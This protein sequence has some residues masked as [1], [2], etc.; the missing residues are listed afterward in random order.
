MKEKFFF[1]LF[2]L[3]SLSKA[4]KNYTAEIIFSNSEIL[5][6][7]EGV[8]ISGT[9]ATIKISGS[10]Y[11]TGS[12]SEGNILINADLVDLNLKD[13]DLSSRTNSP[14]IVKSN[15]QKVTITS[16][17]NVILQDLEDQ[18]TTIGECAVIKI[19]KMS[20]VTF[21]NEKELKLIGK[22]KNVIKGGFKSNI[23][24]NVSDGEYIINAYNNGISSDNLIQFNGGK[25]IINTENGDA[26]KSSPDVGDSESLGKIEVNSGEFNI[27]SHSDAFQAANK[28]II[29]GGN[30]NIKTEDGYDSKSFNKTTMSAKGFKV[31]NNVTG[32][33]IRVYDGEF[34][35]NTADDAFHSNGNLTLI[36]GNYKIYSGDDALHAKFHLI[37]GTKD[38]Y[39]S[40][41]IN[42]LNSYEAIEGMSIRIYSGNINA[43]ARDD[44]LNAAG[45]D[46]EGGPG[47]G[48]R[49]PG[50]R[51]PRPNS[52]DIIDPDDPNPQPGPGPRPPGPRPPRPNSTDI[53]DPDDPNPQPGPGP[54]PPGPWPPGPMPGGRGNAN[55]FISIYGGQLN[56]YCSADGFDSNGNIFIH[57]GDIN[58]FS[59]A[60]GEGRNNE[61]ID[62]DGNFTLFDG[63]LF[64]AGNKG[65]LDVHSGILKGN[66]MYAYYNQSIAANNTLKIKDGNNE[67]IK[68]VT[69]P[70]TVTYTFF[71]CKGFNENYQFY[72]YDTNGNESKLAFNFG[73][74]KSGSDDQDIKADD[75]G[76]YDGKEDLIDSGDTDSPNKNEEPNNFIAILTISLCSGIIVIVAISILLIYK[77]KIC[78]QNK[79]DLLAEQG[80][81]IE[82]NINDDESLIN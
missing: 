82:Y 53:I 80:E 34:D 33:I 38:N 15:L 51:P 12:S 65:M 2:L 62:H 29:R 59:Q 11:I 41:K 21:H 81:I 47:P 56:I 78:K 43:T 48:P 55:Y 25:F 40:P 18:N 6:S 27:Q 23:I 63:T 7:G 73:T 49:P 45:G 26:I 74:P 10:F 19:K 9:K 72:L 57:G 75:G 46:H 54:K 32:C 64:G 4:E 71:S 22:C 58:V 76:R 14:I 69:F 66:Q 24:F 60:S 28:L 3:I 77:F 31:S 5:V 17:G 52:T 61:P 20:T 16:L 36:D 37:I 44:G 50:P 42:I 79:K 30:F 13:L 70:K 67:I 39:K 8:E 1:F 68:E 35:L